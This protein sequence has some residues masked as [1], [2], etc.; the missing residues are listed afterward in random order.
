MTN[1]IKKCPFCGGKAVLMSNDAGKKKTYY[2]MCH[3][4][5]ARSTECFDKT[6]AVKYWNKRLPYG[7]D[8]LNELHKDM[9][10]VLN[11]VSELIDM[12]QLV[13]FSQ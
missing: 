11:A 10:T 1:A 6:Y 2:V 9:R 7:N 13:N 12:I 4:C 3:D 8:N 5:C